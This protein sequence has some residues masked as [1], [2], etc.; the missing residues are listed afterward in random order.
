AGKPGSYGLRAESKAIWCQ[1]VN[2]PQPAPSAQARLL[3]PAGRIKSNLVSVCKSPAAGTF[4]A[5]QAPAACGQN[6]KQSSVSL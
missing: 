3:R 6:Q 5:S 4:G 1:P 2:R